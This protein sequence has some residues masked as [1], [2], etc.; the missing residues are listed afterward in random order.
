M[1]KKRTANRIIKK[2][3]YKKI[4]P[5]VAPGTLAALPQASPTRIRVM[6]YNQEKLEEHDLQHV[7]EVRQYL[8]KWPVVW[9]S[10][11]GLGDVDR[12]NSLGHEFRLHNLVLEDIINGNQRPKM[13]EYD[14]NLFVV[15]RAPGIRD[16]QFSLQQLGL[17]LEKGV[18][19]TFQE[20]ADDLLEPVRTRI[21][22]KSGGRLRLSRPDYLVY[23]LLDVAVDGYFPVLDLYGERLDQYEDRVITEPDRTMIDLIHASRRDFLALRRAVWP[24]RDVLNA[25]ARAEDKFSDDTRV[26]LRDCYDHTIQVIEI[27]TAFQERSSDLINIY[28]SSV[29]N[30]MNEVMKVLTIIATIFMPIGVVA[31]IYGMNFDPGKSPFNMP[32]LGWYFGY[33]FA[34]G[35]MVLVA[36]GFLLYFRWL[37]WLGGKRTGSNSLNNESEDPDRSSQG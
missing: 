29:S 7:E 9:I 16:G 27:L 31:G 35:L 3:E 24:L 36:M 10:V 15:V 4:V 17:V 5:G 22:Q 18:V 37:G 28:L 14:S 19:L 33:P 1:K 13:E 2:T 6:A 21:R 11:E 26:Y 20:N 23:A 12:L 30:K 32:E 8:D 25:L 34:L